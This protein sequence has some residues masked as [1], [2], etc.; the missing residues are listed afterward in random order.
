MLRK[1]D[2]VYLHNSVYL[3]NLIFNWVDGFMSER[4][5]ILKSDIHT[6]FIDK[7]I[8]DIFI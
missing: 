7:N 6:L 2:S 5:N 3:Y 8:I 1:N 4:I